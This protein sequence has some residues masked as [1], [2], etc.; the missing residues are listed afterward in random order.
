[1]KRS[2][3]RYL[4]LGTRMYRGH[5]PGTVFEA[6]LDPAAEQRAID[7]GNI[8]VLERIDPTLDGD[9]QLPHDWPPSEADAAA[10]EAPR[11]ASLISKGG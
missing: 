1:M 6:A 4:V 3:A 10:I 2:Y 5:R 7:R 8:R 9:F 11:G